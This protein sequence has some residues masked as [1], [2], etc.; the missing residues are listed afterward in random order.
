MRYMEG[1]QDE[2]PPFLASFDSFT[3]RFNF[4]RQF[5]VLQ[6]LALKLPPSVGKMIAPGYL[7]FRS[8]GPFP[9]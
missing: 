7:E 2:M 5:P 8:V 9:P 6:R 3:E 1:P 4:M